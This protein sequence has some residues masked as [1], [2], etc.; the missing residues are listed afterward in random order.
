MAFRKRKK[1]VEEDE[2]DE[3]E[4]ALDDEDLLALEEQELQD[5]IK[6]LEARKKSLSPEAESP[7]SIIGRPKRPEKPE[8]K[9]EQVARRYSIF[10]QPERVGIWDAE[11]KEI[12]A[13]GELAILQTQADI[14]ERLE[15]I[16]NLI[17]SFSEG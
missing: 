7:K 9:P 13:E 4:I 5:K 11:T 3:N 1:K 10:R 17:G 6:E 16:E 14:I 12:V 15:R 8:P 2:I